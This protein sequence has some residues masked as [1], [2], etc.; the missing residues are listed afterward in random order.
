[1]LSVKL[2][3]SLIL[4]DTVTNPILHSSHGGG[5]TQH[6]RCRRRRQGH[7][8]EDEDED[9]DD[10]DEGDHTGH[11]THDPTTTA[12]SSSSAAKVRRSRGTRRKINSK[13]KIP[14][15]LFTPTRELIR[16]TYRLSA[17]ARDIG[18]D[19]YPNAS[20]SHIIFSWPSSIPFPHPSSSSSASSSCRPSFSSSSTAT[21]ATTAS[22]CSLPD[23][24]VP[25]PFPSLSTASVSLLRYFV[26][27]SKGLFKLAFLNCDA[28]LG[29]EAN[30]RFSTWDC[31]SLSLISR[32]D[33][34][35]VESMDGF[36]R[37]LAGQ[38]WSLFRTRKN[39]VSGSDPGDDSRFNGMN[40][41]YLFRKVDSN[42][43]RTREGDGSQCRVRELRLPPLDFKNVPLRI[44]QYIMLM[45]DDI[46]YLA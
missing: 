3:R 23:D 9:A 28:Q 12:S 27:L 31:S 38:G 29:F 30:E 46:F 22:F 37:V 40:S 10:E 4:G 34:L 43:V 2:F 21:T 8:D 18:M 7:H 42:R 35:R 15:L 5:Q 32:A 24:A 1:M 11:R 17:I 25:L 36:S 20:L 19:L 26:S 13:S 41:V 39:L 45:T 16:D 33:G 14:L 6:H 44:L